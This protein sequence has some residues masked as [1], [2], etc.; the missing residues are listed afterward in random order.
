M[1]KESLMLNPLS[2]P[3]EK[4]TEDGKSYYY[5]RGDGTPITDESWSL[6]DLAYPLNVPFGGKRQGN[7]SDWSFT[8]WLVN[9]APGQLAP[10][11]AAV[12]G[13]KTMRNQHRTSPH[14]FYKEDSVDVKPK[15]YFNK[16]N[17]LTDIIDNRMPRLT[18]GEGLYDPKVYIPPNE[19]IG[20]QKGDP[21]QSVGDGG[22]SERLGKK[23]FKKKTEQPNIFTDPKTKRALPNMAGY[24]AS[25]D[26]D[27]EAFA[28]DLFAKGKSGYKSLGAFRGK[29]VNKLSEKDKI[30]VW[31]LL[32]E[33]DNYNKGYIEHMIQKSPAMDWYWKMK[34]QDR[35][36]LQNVR[37]AFD[38]RLKTLK[39]VAEGIVHGRKLPNGRFKK[40]L[41]WQTDTLEDRIIVSFEDPDKHSFVFNKTGLGNIVLRRA[42]SN[43]LLGKLGQYL[44]TLYPQDKNIAAELD[45]NISNYI[46][47]NNITITVKTAS[48]KQKTRLVTSSE[49][50]RK[51]LENRV[52]LIIDEAPGLSGMNEAE[53]NKFIDDEI[54]KDMIQLRQ[55]FTWLPQEQTNPLTEV[56]AGSDV[57][58][59]DKEPSGIPELG[60]KPVQGGPFKDVEK[61][62]QFNPRQIIMDIFK[63]RPDE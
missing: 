10:I 4:F 63:D 50:K 15:T 20:T 55:E 13:I 57:F 35:D 11:G 38:T 16:E 52:Q 49:W 32:A 37:M 3:E 46:A 21:L 43:K 7:L 53:R 41:G 17:L 26:N 19:L 27:I 31:N 40:G 33:G 18:Q 51:F 48:G 39:D 23:I 56:E 22:F 45:S 59:Y 6:K 28:M 2:Y 61:T 36:G 8:N 24:K 42:G 47:E 9:A 5:T 29:V 60:S 34:N 25:M 30:E 14:G 1:E 44:T 58:D 12:K 62:E 54:N